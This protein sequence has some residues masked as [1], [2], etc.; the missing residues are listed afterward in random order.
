MSAEVFQNDSDIPRIDA[1]SIFTET[2]ERE[3]VFRYVFSQEEMPSQRKLAD[4]LGV[5]QATVSKIIREFSN[6]NSRYND[7][8]ESI[9]EEFGGLE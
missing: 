8:E 2:E 6:A 5:S 7:L 4:D 1:T 3:I 9:I